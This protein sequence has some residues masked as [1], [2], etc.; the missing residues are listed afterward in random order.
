MGAP[1]TL[2]L[3]R[4]ASHVLVGI[5]DWTVGLAID[6]SGRY[7]K[8]A[9]VLPKQPGPARLVITDLDVPQVV[10]VLESRPVGAD[11]QSA[12]VID[13]GDR[14]AIIIPGESSAADL[15]CDLSGSKL[16]G[17]ATRTAIDRRHLLRR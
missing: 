11:E 17:I 3:G 12:V 9:S 8:I 2:R 1:S 13:L 15:R 5:G 16:A 10:K 4:S 6:V 7:P 14:S